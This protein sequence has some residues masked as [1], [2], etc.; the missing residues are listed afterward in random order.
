MESRCCLM[1]RLKKAVR[2]SLVLLSLLFYVFGLH[3]HY[4]NRTVTAIGALKDSEP[5]VQQQALHYIMS[6]ETNTRDGEYVL[7]K[8]GYHRGGKRFLLLDPY[9]IV[10]TAI[11]ITI[12]FITIKMIKKSSQK[13]SYML[14]D[15]LSYLKEELEHF[16]FSSEITRKD[17]YE[18]CN[19]ILDRLEQRVYDVNEL[20]ETELNKMITFHQD[21]IHQINTP[22][23]TI[24]LII[25]FLS[26]Q[27]AVDSESQKILNYSINKAAGLAHVYMRASKMDA[28]KVKFTY[29]KI[30]VR[31]LTEEILT[32]LKTHAE[33]NQITLSNFCDDSFIYADSAW[34]KEA[35]SN[36]VKNAIEN[37]GMGNK[38]QIS[39]CQEDEVVP[40]VGTWIE[41]V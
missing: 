35:I 32:M 18:E 30:S 37:A 38:V 39:S 36:I 12:V 20:N 31:D 29:E 5:E 15:E 19:Y 41:M 3:V 6:G 13:K 28:G 27:G 21:I 25:D 17:Q 24:K 1:H 23:N 22:L 26:D 10:Y 40:Y 33:F 4:V 16:L 9:V 34:M 11:Y 14:E 8:N 2:A 7:M